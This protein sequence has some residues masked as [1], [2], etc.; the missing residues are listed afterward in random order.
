MLLDEVLYVCICTNAYVKIEGAEYM[1][2]RT[3]DS[4]IKQK[5]SH[6]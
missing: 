1:H 4:E 3:E 5:T 2:T 6:F